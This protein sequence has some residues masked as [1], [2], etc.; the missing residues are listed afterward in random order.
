MSFFL[1]GCLNVCVS[2]ICLSL[3]SSIVLPVKSSVCAYSHYLSIYFTVGQSVCLLLLSV[4][5]PA[6]CSTRLIYLLRVNFFLQNDLAFCPPETCFNL[7]VL[8]SRL[9]FQNSDK[10]TVFHYR[11]FAVKRFGVVSKIVRLCQPLQT[12]PNICWQCLSLLE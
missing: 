6:L 10:I 3:S 7:K 9:T 8:L 12:Y 2:S 11:V 1:C 5:K 4:L